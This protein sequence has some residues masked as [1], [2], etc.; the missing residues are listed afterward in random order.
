MR[1]SPDSTSFAALHG[2]RPDT[3]A[4]LDGAGEPDIPDHA[5]DAVTSRTSTAD[6]GG[7]C[8]VPP[9]ARNSSDRLGRTLLEARAA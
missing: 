8:Y 1:L 7:D 2:L 9:G 5:K 4:P 6:D 3:G